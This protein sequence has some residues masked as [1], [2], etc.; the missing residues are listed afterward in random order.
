M[1]CLYF[2]KLKKLCKFNYSLAIYDHFCAIFESK[3]LAKNVSKNYVFL[4]YFDI[5]WGKIQLV[6]KENLVEFVTLDIQAI[7]VK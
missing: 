5:F 1:A 2:L 3:F 7:H 4:P 6:P